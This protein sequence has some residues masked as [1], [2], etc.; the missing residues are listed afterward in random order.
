MPTATAQSIYICFHYCLWQGG[1]RQRGIKQ[2]DV[3]RKYVYRR[4]AWQAC[5]DITV[6]GHLGIPPGPGVGV[7]GG[8]GGVA[9]IYG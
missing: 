8:G 6:A 9:T 4:W 1:T 7:R 5:C 2:L 3:L